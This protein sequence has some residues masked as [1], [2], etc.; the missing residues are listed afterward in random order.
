MRSLS[1]SNP[2]LS[3]TS[4]TAAAVKNTALTHSQQKLRKAAY[5]FEALF[6]KELL[7]TG[8]SKMSRGMFG[9]GMAEDFFQDSLHDQQAMSIVE[10]GGL[11]IASLIEKEILALEKNSVKFSASETEK[12]NMETR[13]IQA[14]KSYAQKL[15]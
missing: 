12:T 11:G 15:Q 2:P 6:I 5:Q 7:K 10:S 13:K 14:R 3:S 1:L 9:G 4:G 8:S